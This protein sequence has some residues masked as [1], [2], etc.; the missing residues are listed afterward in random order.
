[1]IVDVRGIA[2]QENPAAAECLGTRGKARS[3]PAQGLP[4]DA[5]KSA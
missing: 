4:I 2:D 5:G 1:M 3:K